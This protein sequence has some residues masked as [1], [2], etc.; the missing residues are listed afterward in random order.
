MTDIITICDPDQAFNEVYL[1]TIQH[2]TPS[3]CQNTAQ[4]N[5]TKLSPCS[6]Q[7][8]AW[9]LASLDNVI[10]LSACFSEAAQLCGGTKC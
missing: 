9:V 5:L 7:R 3:T 4:L 1:E 8:S 10:Q 2:V 6:C